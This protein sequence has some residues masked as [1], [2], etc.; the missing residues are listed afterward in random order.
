MDFSAVAHDLRTPLNVM[1]GHMQ[2]L[3]VE[4]LSESGRQRLR[5]LEAQVRRMM[6]LLDGC[7]D[8]APVLRL[9]PVD[10]AAMIRNVV[11][12]LDAVLEQQGIEIT[13]NIEGDLPLLTGDGDLLHRVMVNVLMNAADSIEGMGRIEID[14]CAKQGSDPDV[15]SIHIEITDT[16]AGIPAELLPR[17]FEYGF[18]TKRCGQSRGL[19]LGICREIAHMHGG[20]IRLSSALGR[21]TTVSL[22]LPVKS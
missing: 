19:G 10:L 22:S 18:T 21:G 14:A 1:L 13:S 3:S 17:V 5:V 7:G 11:S 9:A 16:G 6:R 8:E 20:Q 12:E 2:L 4:Q 15:A